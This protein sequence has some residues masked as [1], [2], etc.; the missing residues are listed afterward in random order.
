MRLSTTPWANLDLIDR[1]RQLR[2]V[3]PL[4]VFLY[5]LVGKGLIFDGRAGL[6]YA[7]QRMAAEIVLSLTLLRRDLSR[8]G[9]GP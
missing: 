1:L 4:A 2:V 8:R 3:A 5:C 9:K 6:Y 7:M